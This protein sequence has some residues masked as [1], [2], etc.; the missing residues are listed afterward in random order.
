MK[1]FIR[2]ILFNSFALFMVSQIFP[3]TLKISTGIQTLLMAGFVLTLMSLVVK[4]ILT[5]ITL[6][7]TLLTFG[8]FSWITNAIIL[9]F[10]TLF[11]PQLSINGFFFSGVHFS[12]F[13]I[14]AVQ[15]NT[16]FAFVL[17]SFVLSGILSFL[18]WLTT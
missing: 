14:P 4:P 18:K 3:S 12:G 6:P 2:H 7:I 8:L 11:V 5:L 16:F 10:L 15:V 17:V 1:T 9:Y 13:V